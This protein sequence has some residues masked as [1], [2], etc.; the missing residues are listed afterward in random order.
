[1]DDERK[2]ASKEEVDEQVATGRRDEED[3]Q[4]SDENDE[5]GDVDEQRAYSDAALKRLI[6]PI[7]E[8]TAALY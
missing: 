6:A 7:G 8:A 2:S 1:M 4:G 5:R 3:D